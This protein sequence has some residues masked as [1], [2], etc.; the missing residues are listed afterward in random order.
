VVPLWFQIVYAPTL[1]SQ[2]PQVLNVANNTAAGAEDIILWPL[3]ANSRNELWQYTQSG[4]FVSAVGDYWFN[5]FTNEKSPAQPMVIS[6]VRQTSRHPKSIE[7]QLPLRP[8]RRTGHAS[9]AVFDPT[10]AMGILAPAHLAAN[11]E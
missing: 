9:R 8:L 11:P 5:T 3:Q 2:S 6:S 4:Q 7:R 1:R 10:I